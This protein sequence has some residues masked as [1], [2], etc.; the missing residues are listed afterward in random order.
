M[1][2]LT[3][4]WYLKVASNY[5]RG[6]WIKELMEQLTLNQVNKPNYTLRNGLLRYKERMVIGDNDSIKKKILE[7]L[8][9]SPVRGH[10]GVQN[11]YCRIKQLFYWPGLKKAVKEEYVKNCDVCSR[12]KHE[13]IHPLGLLQPLPILD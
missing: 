8:H 11:T 10:P 5:D 12:C 13:N 7:A 6:E 4:D 1:I 9:N 3:L 2:P